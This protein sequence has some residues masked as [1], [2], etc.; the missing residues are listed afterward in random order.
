M[1]L[2]YRMILTAAPEG[3]LGGLCSL[4]SSAC[5]ST[6]MATQPDP[7]MTSTAMISMRVKPFC[8][9]LFSMCI[10][11]RLMKL[12]DGLLRFVVPPGSDRQDVSPPPLKFFRYL[13]HIRATSF[14]I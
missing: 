5:Q 2:A 1:M 4:P 11:L 8:S 9:L 10:S 3:A 7:R 6:G 14:T 13:K 12:I